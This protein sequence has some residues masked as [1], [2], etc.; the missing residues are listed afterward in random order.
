[1]NILSQYV[2]NIEKLSIVNFDFTHRYKQ[3]RIKI[4]NLLIFGIF[5]HKLTNPS[6][7]WNQF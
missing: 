3:V 4:R 7:D 2:E 6:Y 5:T 1:M